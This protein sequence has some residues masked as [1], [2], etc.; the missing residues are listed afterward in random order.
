MQP[1]KFA[2]PQ[3]EIAYLRQQLN[4]NEIVPVAPTG[5]GA[6]L[7]QE[8][9]PLPSPEASR[10]KIAHQIVESYKKTQPETI[11]HKDSVMSHEEVGAVSLQLAP[12]AHDSQI[13]SLYAIML[14]K[15]VRN[16]LSI[17]DRMQN[18]HLSDD[19]HRFL[20]QYLVAMQG[21]IHGLKKTDEL[22]KQIDATLYE[23]TLPEPD[24]GG[25]SKSFKEMIATM[26]QMLYGMQS[27]GGV[28]SSHSQWYTLELAVPTEGTHASFYVTVP[29][30]A[31]DLFEKQLFALYPEARAEKVTNDPNI[32]G[33][34]GFVMGA[35]AKSGYEEMTV[36]KTWD[37]FE[38]DPIDVLVQVF[39]KLSQNGEGAL[40]Q[41]VINPN[42][43]GKGK[44]FTKSLERLKKGDSFKDVRRPDSLWNTVKDIAKD[45]T[46]KES[47]E[48]KKY[49][50]E[51]EIA[52]EHIAKKLKS[53]IVTTTIRL[54]VSSNSQTQA[55][56]VLQEIKSAF[57]QFTIP[58]AGSFNFVD[59]KPGDIQ[60]FA[61]DATY[62]VVNPNH[63]FHLNLAEVATVFH[64]PVTMEKAAHLK[65]KSAATAPAPFEVPKA[66]VLL[67]Y[68]NHRGVETPIYLAAEDRMRHL[69]VI[70]QTGVGKTGIL[71]GMMAQDIKNG[72]GLCFIDPHGS[73]V[74]SVL[75]MVPPERVDDVIYFDPSYMPRP[76][77]LNM[78]E[79]DPRFPQQKSLI[80][81][82]MMQIFNQLFDMKNAGGPLFEQYF[83]NAAYLVMSHPES[84]CTLME[85]SRV[86]S[87]KVFRDM[88]L[89]H[90]DNPLIRSFWQSAEKTKGDQG[91][92]NF[93]P[94]ITSKFDPL[95]SNEFL[96]PIVA[97]EH[98][99]LNFREIMDNKKILLVNLSKGLLGELNAN[100]LGMILVGKIQMAAL[101]RAD[102]PG[103]K[104]ADFYLY[105]DE[106]QNVTT[107]A[108]ASI[109][110]EA[111]KYRLS[112]NVAHQFMKQLDEKIKAAVLGN[113]GSMAIFRI[114]PSDAAELEPY[115]KPTFEKSDI[116]KLENRNAYV[117]MLA[118]GSPISPFNIK[119]IDWT[120][121]V[122]KEMV[123]P[124]KQLSYLR[125]CRDREE[126]EA[127][128]LSK[129][130]LKDKEE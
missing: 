39:S 10:E 34:A 18:P 30:V 61:H 81:D 83:K 88:K 29:N 4:N 66:G 51:D 71:M 105:I 80:I 106:F 116:I 24:D 15:G 72:D 112:L 127:E 110:S 76:M 103:K 96:R 54:L 75:S 9:T 42:D 97:Q 74:L 84:G 57:S 95:L 67:G 19:F 70:G 86:M 46:K 26:E 33:E 31:R 47:E 107:P 56:Q 13:E 94:Y 53:P 22:Y 125:Y 69:Y 3:E 82:Q 1:Y 68:N 64:F 130:N 60:S 25:K 114:E 87:D 85:I 73:D 37:G 41:I 117:K 16:T 89:S 120:K 7:M 98:S 124:I 11:L 52:T 58:Y 93:V 104:Y 99:A 92:E 48:G 44:E 6:P 59:I 113:V 40:L 28:D 43:G 118:G 115:F 102:E 49:K 14:D 38:T 91:L 32:F 111:R 101:S 27:V 90:C 17:I 122:N 50:L 23:I 55:T 12:E 20:V 123:D 108:I 36:M 45:I 128:I 78:M 100:L 62:R 129:Y 77:G 119:T 2:S 35:Y 8:I 79:F 126:V 109:L 63:L 65:R 121:F 21:T 5:P